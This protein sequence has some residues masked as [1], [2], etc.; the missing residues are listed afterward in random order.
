MHFERQVLWENGPEFQLG[1]D[2]QNSTD[3]NYE[4]FNLELGMR[5]VTGTRL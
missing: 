3:L 1:F 4:T 2:A 5:N